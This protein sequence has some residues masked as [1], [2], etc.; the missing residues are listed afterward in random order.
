MVSDFRPHESYQ[1]FLQELPELLQALEEDLIHLRQDHSVAKMYRL[2]RTAHSLKGGAACVGLSQI[3]TLAH[4]LETVF[5]ALSE[6]RIPVDLELENLLLQAYDHLKS[7]LLEDRQPNSTAVPASHPIWQQLEAKLNMPCPGASSPFLFAVDLEKGIQRLHTILATV[8]DADLGE[9]L[10]AQIEIFRGLGD[11]A[12]QPLLQTIADATLTALQQ[13]P[14]SA[15][16]IGQLATADFA[17]AQAVLQDGQDS[18]G[19]V[20]LPSAELL[21]FCDAAPISLPEHPALSAAAELSANMLSE[22]PAPPRPLGVRQDWSRLEL[23]SN[24]VDELVT[25]DNRIQ[26]QYEQQVETVK[27]LVQCFS[28]VQQL[29]QGL[30]RWSQQLPTRAAADPSHPHP[31]MNGISPRHRLASSPRNQDYW[32]TQTQAMVEEMSHLSEALQDLTLLDQQLQPILKQKQKTLKQVQTSVLQARMLPVGE[33]LNQFPRMVRDLAVTEQKRVALELKGTQ[34]LIDKAILEKLYDPLVHLVRNAFDHGI[35]PPEVRQILGK[36][37]QGKITIRAWHRG[38]QTYIEVQDDGQGIDLDRVRAAVVARNAV[39]GTEAATLS[40]HRLYE[41][42]FLPGFS[43]TEA[44]SR[45][46]GRGMGLYAV[47]S[48]INALKGVVTVES[49]L[50]RGTTFTLRLPRTL[51]ITKLL[52]FTIAGNL[53]A[54]PVDTLA[55]IT[56]ASEHLFQTEQGQQFFHWQGR[57][58]PVCPETLLSYRY[59]R[60][61]DGDGLKPDKAWQ[62][63]SKTPML[64]VSHGD[65]VIAL[66]VDEILVEQEL[67][68]KP[69]NDAITPP[70]TLAGCTILADGRLAP[71]LDGAALIEKWQERRYPPLANAAEPALLSELSIPRVPMVLVVDD[72]LTIRH[73]LSTTLDKAGYQVIQAKDGWE[74]I[75][76]LRTQPD[77]AAVICDIEMPRMNGLEFLTRC[78]QQG[79][80]LPIIVL[81]YRSS[82]KYRQLAQQLGATHYLTK[83]YLDKELLSTL[84]QCLQPAELSESRLKHPPD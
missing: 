67:A 49:R 29:M 19:T 6:Q 73:A 83:P 82:A 30:H 7:L 68:I 21:Q 60:W 56:V 33:L 5:K 84:E 22:A 69:F 74:A 45:L 16:R 70:S 63:P 48:Q 81:T 80:T 37:L 50:G 28:R 36:P 41:Y 51:S 20:A 75:T 32:Q 55:A 57:F 27:S 42:L 52:V 3:Q 65:R 1:F 43:T 71:V 18:Q 77:V 58:V 78:R 25:Q 12:Q 53:F 61:G 26:L 23:L 11:I 40:D 15:R 2:M 46:S 13:H 8:P 35:E 14:Q 31:I 44:V 38:N 64:L 39:T 4:N 10:R 79:Y 9:A 34:T 66:K 17:A 76:Q 54:I 62:K 24:L 72:S 59:P 47:Q